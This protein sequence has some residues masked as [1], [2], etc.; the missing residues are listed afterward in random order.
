MRVTYTTITNLYVRFATLFKHISTHS[1]ST[2]L[3]IKSMLVNEM[4]FSLL[5]LDLLLW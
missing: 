4:Q 1:F 5:A 3:L 2:D